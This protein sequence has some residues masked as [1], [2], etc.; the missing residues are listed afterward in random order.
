MAGWYHVTI[1]GKD[2]QSIFGEIIADKM[3]LNEIGKIVEEEWLKT[4][5]IRSNVELDEYVVMPNHLHGIAIIN[6]TRRGVSQYAPTKGFRSPSQSLGAIIRGFKCS[7]TKRINLTRTTPFRPVWQRGFYEHIIRKD[8]DLHHI[9]QYIANN[10]M[11]WCLDGE[12]PEN[13]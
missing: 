12:N 13:F 9:R 1:V 10:P 6:D 2:R 11:R 3:H 7:S 5:A 4:P 8:A